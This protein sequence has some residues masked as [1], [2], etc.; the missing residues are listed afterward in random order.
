L[1]LL[2]GG[3]ALVLFIFALKKVEM[4]KKPTLRIPIFLRQLSESIHPERIDS[5]EQYTLI[6]A[7]FS[8]LVLFDNSGRI[9]ANLAT[10]FYWQDEQTLVFE[11]DREQ[12][13]VDGYSVGAVDALL[14]LKRMI[15]LNNN[16][17]G[18]ISDRLEVPDSF[19]KLED[20]IPNLFVKDNKLHLRLKKRDFAILHILASADYAVIPS[21]SIDKATLKIIDFRN[22]TGPFYLKSEDDKQAVLEQNK[23]HF[24]L[25]DSN[26]NE[27]FCLK[28]W[29]SPGAAVDAFM[30]GD[31]DHI[32]TASPIS[33]KDYIKMSEK[34]DAQ[35]HQTRDIM[36]YFGI[37]TESARKRFSAQERAT[38]AD[39]IG[40]SV[41]KSIT[42][43]SHLARPTSQ[44]FHEDGVGYVSS[45]ELDRKKSVVIDS[46][47]TQRLDPKSLD[48]NI[49]SSERFG[50]L[51]KKFAEQ[52]FR[53]ISLHP[54][55][56]TL[57]RVASSEVDIIF[58]GIDVG[59]KE[60]FT[61]L[62]FAIELGIFPFAPAEGRDWL[63]KLSYNDDS[64]NRASMIQALH[65]KALVTEP[66]IIPL[67]RLPTFAV[68]QNGWKMD[69]PSLWVTERFW[70]VYKD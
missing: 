55:T 21:M 65:E 33:S 26:A 36:L 24:R 19:R 9:E 50:S 10:R 59:L 6:N 8:P 5:I 15:L 42:K 52:E 58:T 18:S 39:L 56:D 41:R 11:F 68:T 45:P 2:L 44:F 1:V 49:E 47:S 22:T 43:V 30:R 38:I 34:T 17:H 53:K 28:F 29:N 3:L 64:K 32:P 70:Q 16:M 63:M 46:A 60:D 40:Q 51:V 25:S 61:G 20:A 7:L 66:T 35:L 37:F 57:G 31:L 4:S 54:R 69:L 62:S 23:S 48:I 67:Y 13:T 14:S 27:I 12:K